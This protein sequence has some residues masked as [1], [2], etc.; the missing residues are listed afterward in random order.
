MRVLS[1]NLLVAL[2][3]AALAG[4]VDTAHLAVGFVVGYAALWL[5]RP[6]LG[7]TRYFR[8]VVDVVS[9]LCFFMYELVLS[10]LRVAWD[11]LTPTSYRRPGV[12]AVPLENASDTE[13]TLL[14][15]LVTLTPG[16]LSL[17]VSPDRTCLYVHAMFVDDP[18][19][20]KTEIKEG[21]ERRVLEV[22]R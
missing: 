4:S 19:S 5:A 8:K 17:D 15:N 16:S 21:F 7:E 10:N 14:A 9:F 13:I 22:L 11:V 12:V 3:W 20:L 18:E 2:L 1:L 6:V